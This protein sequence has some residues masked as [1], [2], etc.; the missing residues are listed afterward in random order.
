MKT[1]YSFESSDSLARFGAWVVHIHIVGFGALAIF[2]VGGWPAVAA[3]LLLCGLHI[4]G[5][6]ASVTV[7]DE[8]VVIVKKW[9]FIPYKIHRAAEIADVWYGGD[10]GL[11]EGAMCVV[12]KLGDEEICIGTS[13]NMGELYCGL[14]PHAAS[15]RRV[16]A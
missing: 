14:S 10:W 1:R 13:Q 2:G 12:V 5:L 4:A 8:G 11:E 6:R 7:G 16:T 3:V 9:L 15:N